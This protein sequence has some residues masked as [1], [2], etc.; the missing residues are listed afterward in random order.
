[1]TW[2]ATSSNDNLTKNEDELRK[3]PVDSP[4]DYPPQKFWKPP[5]SMTIE[6]EKGVNQNIPSIE[7]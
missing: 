5:S 2:Y 1:M 3:E 4:W 6:S 7:P